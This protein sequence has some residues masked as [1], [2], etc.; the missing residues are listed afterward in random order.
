[1]EETT[2]NWLARALS[3]SVGQKFVM[4]LTGLFLCF[5][6]VI[7]LA[8]NMLMYAGPGAY[9]HYAESLHDSE[10]LII[11]QVML[12]TAFVLH[13]IVAI[14]LT[15]MNSA[16]RDRGY[17]MKRSKKPERMVHEKV[18]PDSTMFYTGLIILAFTIYHVAEIKFEMLYGDAFEAK[19]PYGQA[20]FALEHG[21]TQV[22]YLIGS[23]FVGIHVSHGLASA[24]QS[25][26]FNH[27]KYTPF[28]HR[29]SQ[30]FGF[31]V[32]I[33]FASFGIARAAGVLRE[34]GN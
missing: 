15:R 34:I 7:H 14:T 30:V 23:I 21:L 31:V 27:P 8:G 26:G 5:F 16:A 13:L 33:G 19:D 17:A 32:A 1:V 9:N 10:L 11:A 2:L 25:V 22:V 28:I 4:G 29:A 24:C 3:S 20:M 6:L 18:A 12:Y